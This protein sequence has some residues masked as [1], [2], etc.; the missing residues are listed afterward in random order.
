MEYVKS[1]GGTIKFVR[2]AEG[3]AAVLPVLEKEDS[4]LLKSCFAVTC[5]I[6]EELIKQGIKHPRDEEVIEI[7]KQVIEKH[8]MAMNVIN[9][10]LFMRELSKIIMYEK[11]E[12][13]DKAKEIYD[14]VS[15][16]ISLKRGGQNS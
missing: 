1:R 7:A 11:G 6:G 14:V 4:E 8:K 3:E 2:G 16:R 13:A 12:R 5:E 9:S 10:M 15:F